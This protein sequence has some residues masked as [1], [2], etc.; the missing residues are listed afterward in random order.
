M[1][2]PRRNYGL[3]ARLPVYHGYV[4]IVRNRHGM[5]SSNPLFSI[6]S[7]DIPAIDVEAAITPRHGT[8]PSIEPRENK[9]SG[10]SPEF[11][12]Q[13]GTGLLSCIPPGVPNSRFVRPLFSIFSGV[14]PAG[15][16]CEERVEK[17]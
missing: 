9:V 15:S 13:S 6:T 5:S 16:I 1:I 12:E 7:G 4:R 8:T 11:P 2:S 17:R 10:G 3:I 14:I